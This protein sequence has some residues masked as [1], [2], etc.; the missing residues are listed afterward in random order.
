MGMM[1][2]LGSD[3]DPD[4]LSPKIVRSVLDTAAASGFK[5][6]MD[7][8]FPGIHIQAGGPFNNESRLHWLRSNVTL[9]RNHRALLG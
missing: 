9:V 2:G 8:T 6:M 7:M 3:F 4:Y 1:Y 5:V